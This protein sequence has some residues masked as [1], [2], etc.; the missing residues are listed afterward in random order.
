MA[1]SSPSKKIFFFSLLLVAIGV[2]SKYQYI[3]YVSPNA[4][5]VIVCGY[6]VLATGNLFRNV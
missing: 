3:Q 1:L 4:L 5:W 2:V 6:A